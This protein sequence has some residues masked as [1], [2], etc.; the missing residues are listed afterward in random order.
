MRFF[1][2]KEPE[3]AVKENRVKQNSAP[4]K[5]TDMFAPPAETAEQHETSEGS[6]SKEERLVEQYI[7]QDNQEAAA[8][9]L[10]ELIV[11]YAKQKNF[12]TK[13]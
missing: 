1:V 12:K 11:K 10:F 2:Q 6:L 8:K 7:K 13:L 4:Q 3:P 5:S 9:L